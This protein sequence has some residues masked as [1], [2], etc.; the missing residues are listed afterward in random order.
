MKWSENDIND[1]EVCLIHN[2]VM[3]NIQQAWVEPL[4][5]IIDIDFIMTDLEINLNKNN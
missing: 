5:N 1:M 4:A 3:T 2:K